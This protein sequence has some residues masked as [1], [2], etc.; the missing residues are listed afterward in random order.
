MIFVGKH[1]KKLFKTS[2]DSD[3]DTEALFEGEIISY[4][5]TYWK[6]HYFTDG[7]EEDI[8]IGEVLEHLVICN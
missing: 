3:D 8:S 4:S 1:V 7:D 6:I 2:S 5:K